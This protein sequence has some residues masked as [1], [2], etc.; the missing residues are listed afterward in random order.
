M[1][2]ELCVMEWAKGCP[3]REP[4]GTVEMGKVVADLDQDQ[5]SGDLANAGI[6]CSKVHAQA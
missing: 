5:R 1:R 2:Y 4:V 6:V 3:G